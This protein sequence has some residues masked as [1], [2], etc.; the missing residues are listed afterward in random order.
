[1]GIIIAGLGPGSF[2]HITLE[3][4]ELLTETNSLLL[5]T[6]KHPCVDILKERGVS[7]TSFDYLYEQASD[8]ASLYQQITTAV[9][10]KAKQGED[11]VYAVPGSPLVAEKTVE[12]IATQA[13]EAGINLR[14]FR[15]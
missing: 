14:L 3:T 12:L 13:E 8:F 1:M 7:F 10:K 4:W 9:I 15:P 5:R 2:K 6:A 11:I